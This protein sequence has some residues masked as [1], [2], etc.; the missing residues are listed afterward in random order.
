MYSPTSFT[1]IYRL[2]SQSYL[3]VYSPTS[4]T[5]IYRLPSQ[6]Y[7]NV[8]GPTS[9]TGRAQALCE[10]GVALDPSPGPNIRK[11]HT[12]SVGGR[13]SFSFCWGHGLVVF[14]APLLSPSC[15]RAGWSDEPAQLP[16]IAIGTQPVHSAPRPCRPTR[17]RWSEKRDGP[18]AVAPTPTQKSADNTHFILC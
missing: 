12:V 4:F 8:Y 11:N 2:P 10:H 7:L 6:R 13:L 3:N 9:F 17:G 1:G 15:L 5:G 16:A 14:V 18:T